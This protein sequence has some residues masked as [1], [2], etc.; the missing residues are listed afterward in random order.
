MKVFLGGMEIAVLQ[1]L[2][3]KYCVLHLFCS[4][5]TFVLLCVGYNT[6]LNL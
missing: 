2:G 6:Y 3:T 4:V 5:E 1:F